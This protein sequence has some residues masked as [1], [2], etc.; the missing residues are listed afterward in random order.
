MLYAIAG[1]LAL[2]YEV[3]WSQA[4]VQFLSTRAYAFA[5]VL[6]TYLLGLTLGSAVMSGWSDRLRQP[7]LVFGGLIAGA[8]LCALASFTVVDVWLLQAQ[9]QAGVWAFSLTHSRMAMKLARFALATG[10][11]VLP[12]TLLLGAAYPVA[13]RLV[14]RAEQVGTD[15]GLV[16]A[17]NTLGGI[18]G[19][20]VTG[21]VLVP[22]IGLVYSLVLLTSV[23][24][25]LGTIAIAQAQ[26]GAIGKG[27]ITIL[28][29]GAIGLAALTP[30]DN[31]AQL[32]VLQHPG[33]LLF[34][35]ESVGN[36]VAVIEQP[37]RHGAFHRLYIQG[38]SNTGDVFP[39]LRYM[40]LQALLPLIVHNGEPRAAM[41]VGL[42]SGITS[43]SL[44]AYPDLDERITYELLSPVVAAASSFDGNL[45]VT[46]DRRATIR[47]SD[48]R[49]ELLR[50]QK[51][52]DLITLEPPPPAAAGVV[53]LYSRDFYELAQAK[54]APHGLLAQWW[55][56]A[57]QNDA[58]SRS[59]VRSLLDVFPYVTLWSTEFHEMMLIGSHQPLALDPEQI[60]DRYEQPTVKAALTAVGIPSPQALLATYVTDRAGLERYVQD[61]PPVTDD[62]PLIEYA[63]WVRPREITRVLPTVMRT[64]LSL[65]H[66]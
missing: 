61:A 14:A 32:L 58:D 65:I 17:L 13:M 31:F 15:A 54:L 63:D 62:R 6:A 57:T 49:H 18:I 48:G 41:V 46:H 21:F 56:L 26:A 33:R 42:G 23:A 10:V 16:T 25:I 55:P 9:H 5:L 64:H 19:T 11:F 30:G 43:G 59:L 45:D 8:G 1:G 29:V 40:R 2:G 37:T 24:V 51:K 27:M 36:T 47:V 3:I 38:V 35:Q 44:L 12:P 4:I 39:S 7:W 50:T 52:F 66:I 34:Y 60:R 53:N 22:Q 20:V 28:G